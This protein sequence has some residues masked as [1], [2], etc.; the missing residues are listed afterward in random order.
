MALQFENFSKEDWLR[1]VFRKS[2][3]KSVENLANVSTK[4]F[5]LFCQNKGLTEPQM[6]VKYQELFALKQP[7]IRNICL[8]LDKFV[9]FLGQDHE[10]IILNPLTD[11]T[12]KKKSPKTIK[13][14]FHFV[15]SYLRK[16]HGVK[17]TNEDIKDYVIF[18]KQRKEPRRAIEIKKLK[19]IV[20]YASPLRRALY[21]VLISSGI[22]IGEAL[23]LTKADFHFDEDPVRVTIKAEITKTKEGRDTFISSE[24]VDELKPFLEGKNDNE[25]PFTTYD[26]IDKAVVREDQ[27]FMELRKKLG[28]L[29]IEREEAKQRQLIVNGVINELK[30]PKSIFLERYPNSNRFI[31]NIHAFRA[32]FHTKASQKHGSDYAHALIGHGAYLKEYYRETPEEKAKKYKELEPSLLIISQ[33]LE[34]E[35][36]KDKKIEDLENEMQELQAKMA[37]WEVINNR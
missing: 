5:D 19:M 13:G 32:Y 30:E 1:Q 12:F 29:E 14:Y 18:P 31:I 37:R 17:L 6:I 16:C 10:E 4:M 27:N 3:S 34:S 26:E 35:K 23:A 15:K 7:D 22:R 36:T 25:K 24:A 9:Q 2:E 33:K 11:F 8:S 20:K 21:L 28:K